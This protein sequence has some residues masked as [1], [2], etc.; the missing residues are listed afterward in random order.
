MTTDGRNDD[1]ILDH[2]RGEALQHGLA[3]SS[4]M[5]DEITRAAEIDAVLACLRYVVDQGDPARLLEIGC[6][7]G[8]MLQKISERHPELALTGVDFS[9]DMVELARGRAIS[10]C[11]VRQGDVR[12]LD[13]PDRAF[14]I[15]LS[16]RC[17][18]N[19]LDADEQAASFEELDRVLAPGGHLVLIEAFTDGAANLN[20]ARD[21][22]GLPPNPPPHHN[23]WLDKAAFLSF[24]AGRYAEVRS[25]DPSA[26]LPPRNFLSSHY[27]VS[28]VF[29]PSVTRREVLYNTEFVKFFRFLPPMGEYS[30]IQLF[31]LRKLAPADH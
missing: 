13:F 8:H 25:A 21:E 16:E 4:T 2:Y 5:A 1:V 23:R 10:R 30:P 17:V 9:P 7:N 12:S 31:F 3:A 11:E 14:E 27:F 15:V 20:R 24:A 19:V 29:Y 22:M 18:I 28:R 6:G 26:D